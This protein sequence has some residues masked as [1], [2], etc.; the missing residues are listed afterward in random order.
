MLVKHRIGGLENALYRCMASF[1]VKH[2]IG[3]LEM[4]WLKCLLVMMVKHRIG[5]LE[6]KNSRQTIKTLNA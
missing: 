5:N 1:T 4:L 6:I 3:G 2:R